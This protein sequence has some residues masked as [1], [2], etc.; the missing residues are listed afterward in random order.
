MGHLRAPATSLPDS[1]SS[2]R[3]MVTVAPS[4]RLSLLICEVGGQKSSLQVCWRSEGQGSG[5]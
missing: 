3:S 2:P 1:R 4:P 5:C